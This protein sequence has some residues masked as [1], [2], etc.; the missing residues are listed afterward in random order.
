MIRTKKT[1][2]TVEVI[3]EDDGP[4]FVP[5]D[6]KDTKNKAHIGIVNVRERVENI[7]GGELIIDSE[8][9]KGTKAIIKLPIGE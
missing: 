5:E 2:D 7:A 3:V 6:V 9:G 1:G 8:I 4:G